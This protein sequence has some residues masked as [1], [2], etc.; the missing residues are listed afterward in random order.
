[1]NIIFL[2]PF[3][4]SVSGKPIK[5]LPRGSASLIANIRNDFPTIDFQ[6]Y[7][8]EEEINNTILKDC[9][10]NFKKLLNHFKEE[11]NQSLTQKINLKKYN[12]FFEQI[13]THLNLGKYDHYFFFFL[14]QRSLGNKCQ[15]FFCQI[16]KK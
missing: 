6:I 16:F 12:N 9:R 8:L 5:W 1:M 14:R 13:T 15:Y 11:Y 7:D 10:N 4:S 3:A 2:Y